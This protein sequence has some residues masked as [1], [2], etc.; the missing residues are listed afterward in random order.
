MTF[1][2][3]ILVIA[4]FSGNIDLTYFSWFFRKPR[5]VGLS[6]VPQRMPRRAVSQRAG[7]AHTGS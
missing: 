5:F 7:S 6:V 3:S 4:I 1:D 2:A